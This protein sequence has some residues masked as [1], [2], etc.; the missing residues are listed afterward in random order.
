[1]KRKVTSLLLCIALLLCI[2]LCV[3]ASEMDPHVIDQAGLLSD[4]ERSAL[5]EAAENL[6]EEFQ[7][8]VVILTV[9]SLGGQSAEVYADDYYDGHGY[10]I[11]ENYS[12]VLYLLAMEEREWY[13][14]TCGDAI[15]AL[16]D[17]GIQQ[18]G[19]GILV[20]LSDGRYYDA[21]NAYLESLPYYFEAWKAGSPIDGFAD[22]SGDY[23]HGTQDEVLYYE[24]DTGPSLFL[25]IMIGAVAA[26]ATVFIMAGTMNTKRRQ[27]GARDYMKSGSYNLHICQDLFLYSNISKTRRQ[28]NSSNSSGGGSSVHRSS[29]GRSHGG[30]GGK[31]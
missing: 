21:F 16:T 18:V 19:E 6:S 23:Y 15:Y 12:G 27:H 13:I 3:S 28:E 9:D 20:Y 22:Y 17:Y 31:F 8:D 5:E 2:C 11:G 26:A 14:S 7:L 1:M 4:S 30:G 25:S 10:G 29:S 24:E